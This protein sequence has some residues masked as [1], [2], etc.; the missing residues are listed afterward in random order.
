MSQMIDLDKI[1][2]SIITAIRNIKKDDKTY[3]LLES[4]IKKDGQ[5]HP[6]TVRKL[7]EEEKSKFNSNAEYGIIDGHHRF[8][9]AKN[10]GNTEISAE[11]D[12]VEASPV[13][14]L[15]LALQLN[16]TSIRMTP[17]EKGKVIFDLIKLYEDMGQKKNAEEIGQDVF[18]LQTSMAYK[19]LQD[20]KRANHLTTPKTETRKSK[21]SINSLQDA[22]KSLPTDEN[23]ITNA[24]VQ[25][26]VNQLNVIRDVE[27]QLRFYKS[28]LYDKDGVKEAYKNQKQ[29]SAT[30]E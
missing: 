1:D 13:R 19:C 26:C 18:G 14:D 20:Y 6:I 27:S 8:S 24:N 12:E 5:R 10:L 15:S 4:A 17:V 3:E 7:T 9:V 21:F 11:I 28:L 30:T 2:D 29:K 25:D 16:N 23:A 22:I